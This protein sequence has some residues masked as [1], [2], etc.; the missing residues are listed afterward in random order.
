M[1]E[2]TYLKVLTVSIGV[3]TTLVT[4]V[5]GMIAW[6]LKGLNDKIVTIQAVQANI[7]NQHTQ[8]TTNYLTRFTNMETKMV[9]LFEELRGV[10]NNHF[11]MRHS[12]VVEQ[13]AE[14]QN[15]LMNN[16]RRANDASSDFY[17]EHAGA[18]EWVHTEMAKSHKRSKVDVH[19]D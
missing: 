19:K 16:V 17:K 7:S 1:T 5:A 10:L 15:Q 14:L 11:T 18:L 8:I 4:L 3:I 6:Y 13:L 2:E 12:E 9:S